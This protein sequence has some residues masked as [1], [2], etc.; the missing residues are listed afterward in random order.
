[1]KLIR[2]FGGLLCATCGALVGFATGLS[3]PVPPLRLSDLPGETL[4]LLD[5]T[6]LLFSAHYR[7]R[8]TRCVIFA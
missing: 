7:T 6:S 2:R 4:F 3:A 1:M 5:G 8:G